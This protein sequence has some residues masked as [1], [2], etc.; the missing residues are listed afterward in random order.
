MADK[1]QFFEDIE[2][3]GACWCSQKWMYGVAQVVSQKKID[4]EKKIGIITVS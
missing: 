3:M 2:D 1:L 4:S